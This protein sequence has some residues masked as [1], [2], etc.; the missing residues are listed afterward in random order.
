[1]DRAAATTHGS[2]LTMRRSLPPIAWCVD[3]VAAKTPDTHAATVA[4]AQ[5]EE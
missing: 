2:D 4:A 3:P 5:A 1:M